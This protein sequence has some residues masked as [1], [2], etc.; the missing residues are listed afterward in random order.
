MW[1]IFKMHTHLSFVEIVLVRTCNTGIKWNFLLFPFCIKRFRVESVQQQ[2]SF[3]FSSI[4]PLIPTS[5]RI[6]FYFKL[7]KKKMLRGRIF[8]IPWSLSQQGLSKS[9]AGTVRGVGTSR[10]R[11]WN[12]L[13]Y[14]CHHIMSSEITTALYAFIRVINNQSYQNMLMTL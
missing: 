4:T 10:V 7:K 11:T 12:T 9:C 2:H 13:H 3:R 1:L 14:C 8:Q 5:R 6:L